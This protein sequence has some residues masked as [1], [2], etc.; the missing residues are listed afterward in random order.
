MLNRTKAPAAAMKEKQ[1]MEYHY[2]DNTNREKGACG[3]Y[4]NKNKDKEMK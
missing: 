4:N 3:R 1:N 2:Y